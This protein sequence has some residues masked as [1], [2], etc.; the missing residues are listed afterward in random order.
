MYYFAICMSFVGGVV[1]GLVGGNWLDARDLLYICPRCKIR[2]G[3]GTIV[4]QI[5]E[6]AMSEIAESSNR[7]YIELCEY[8][9]NNPKP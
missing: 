5:E 6:L 8:G 7:A 1:V 3:N 2:G 9:S 4:H